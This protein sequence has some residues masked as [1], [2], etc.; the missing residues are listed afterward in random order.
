MLSCFWMPA[1]PSWYLRLPEILV[2]L[3][4]EGAPPFF[5]RIA[6]EK[7]FRVRRRQA[8]RLLGAARGYQIGKTFLVER[9]SLIDFLERVE[10][11]GAAGQARARKDRVLAVLNEVS[12]H[13]AAQR[14]H[15]GTGTDVFRRKPADLPDSIELV[16]PGRIQISYAGAEDLL[17]RIADLAAAATNDFPAFRKRYEGH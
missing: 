15:I 3:R 9:Q 14:V 8:I 7:L 16:A 13:A 17:A 10:A 4:A 1:Q 2:Q 12:N 5:D 6:V 11:S